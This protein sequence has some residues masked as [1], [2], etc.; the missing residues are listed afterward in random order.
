MTKN[1][2]WERKKSRVKLFL[3]LLLAYLC[4]IDGKFNNKRSGPVVDPIL[5]LE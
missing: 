3:F 5:L 1:K 4:V 2:D